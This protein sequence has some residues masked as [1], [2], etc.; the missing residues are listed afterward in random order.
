MSE[1]L[2]SNPLVSIVLPVYNRSD[3]II[4]AIQSVID[5]TY[6][7]WELVIADNGSNLE[8]QKILEKYYGMEKVNHYRNEVNI[9]LFPNL[10]KAIASCSGQYILLLCD[11]D[12][13]LPECLKISVN[14]ALKFP[15]ADLILAP[16]KRVDSENNYLPS[17]GVYKY[18]IFASEIK[19]SHPEN[20]LPILMQHGSINGNLT[21][22]FFKRDLPQKVGFFREDWKHSNDWEWLYRVAKSCP[23]LLSPISVAVVRNHLGQTSAANFRDLSSYREKAKMVKILLSDSYIKTIKESDKWANDI[24]QHH[25]WLALKALIS[26]N[27]DG[28]R[29][30]IQ[31]VHTTT[32]L[33]NAF[34][35]MILFLPVRWRKYANKDFHKS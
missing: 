7:N 33:P 30:L 13:L 8:T 23:I 4:Q 10:N 32:D 20:T 6:V 18:S 3:Y 11:D 12:F 22:M 16:S 34:W 1:E 14:N 9:G 29:N 35:A 2:L 28:F 5:Q 26:G 25:L 15:S 21:G 19:L 24:M 17:M 27:W 31:E